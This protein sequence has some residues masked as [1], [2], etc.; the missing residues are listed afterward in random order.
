MSTKK[1]T[2]EALVAFK[3]KFD[4]IQSKG[5]IKSNRGH[6]TGIGKTFEDHM[7]ILENNSPLADFK[8]WECKS[9]RFASESMVTLFTLSPQPKGVNSHLRKTYGYADT[10]FPNVKCIRNTLNAIRPSPINNSTGILI[11]DDTNKKL[12]IVIDGADAAHWEYD[13][14]WKKAHSKIK[15]TI[16]IQAD[17]RKVADAEFFKYH[18]F[19]LYELKTLSDFIGAIKKGTVKVDIRL[20]VYSSGKNAGKLHDHGTAFR[21]F[22]D[23]IGDIFNIYE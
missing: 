5:E 21:I 3:L 4:E 9:R 12:K 19:T 15:N 16:V 6:D 8:G 2:D 11:C 10:H 1:I 13:L 23:D 14:L 18:S 7:D 22:M 17:H 20:G